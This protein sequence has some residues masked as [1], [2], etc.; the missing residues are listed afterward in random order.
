VKRPF[1][2]KSNEPYINR[3]I[4]KPYVR[5]IGKDGEQLGI[6]DI[7]KAV[8]LA[9]ELGLDLVQ[10]AEKADPPV[11]KIMDYG[12]HKYEEKKKAQ[13]AKKK[14]VVI[15]L[16]EVQIRPKT[17]GHD[18][19]HKSKKALEFLEEGNKVKLIVFYRGREMEHLGVGWVTLSNFLKKLNDTA[20]LEVPPRMEGRRLSCT[21]GPIP[22]GK[23]MPAGH[24][25]ASLPKPPA[26]ATLPSA[27]N[28]VPG[29]APG[30]API[31]R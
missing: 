11:C 12:K 31:K 9:E 5:V 24:L 15:E 28:I 20:V 25:I 3:Q 26:N 19:D 2:Q 23:K 13:V 6:L 1:N 7:R 22:A 27:A 14:Q 4:R 29:A 21:L 17:E 30:A 16:K 18:L 8:L 10:V